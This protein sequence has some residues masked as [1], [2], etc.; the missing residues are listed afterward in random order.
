MVYRKISEDLKRRALWL[1]DNG[2]VREDICDILGVSESSLDRWRNNME[3][4][5]SVLPPPNPNQGRPR[6][7]N[8]DMT[9]DLYTLLE[10][11]PNLYLDEIQEWLA[12]AHDIGISV[13]A[14]HQ[15]MEDAGIS[16]KLLRKAAVE[17]DEVA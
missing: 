4:Y 8:A 3:S 13:S 10:E 2:Y 16:Y 12:A 9:H 17:R 11:A 6:I 7:L 14:L 15:N 5:S 1:W